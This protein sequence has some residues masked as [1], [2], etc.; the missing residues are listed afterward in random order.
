MCDQDFVMT[1]PM[2]NEPLRQAGD[3]GIK[4]SSGGEFVKRFC[5]RKLARRPGGLHDMRVLRDDAQACCQGCY[6]KPHAGSRRAG[7]TRTRDLN[8]TNKKDI[9]DPKKPKDPSSAH[10]DRELYHIL[11]VI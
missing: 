1:P 7:V 4:V 9:K 11:R 10:T 8:A 5:R 2:R 6:V 3:E